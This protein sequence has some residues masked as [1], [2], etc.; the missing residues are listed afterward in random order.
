MNVVIVTNILAPY[1]IGLFEEIR[2][3]CGDLTVVTLADRHEDRSWEITD[4][5]FETRVLPGAHF[6]PSGHLVSLHWNFGMARALKELS[7]D[8]LISGGYAP[9]NLAAF[10]F[11]QRYAI[12]HISWGELI[13]EDGAENSVIKR[14]IRR[15]VISRSAGCI[16]S[17]TR[18]KR[19][20]EFYGSD[21][22]N[23][24][25]SV[26]PIDVKEYSSAAIRGK[27]RRS[28]LR[29]LPRRGGP[30]LLVV[31]RLI[32]IKGFYPLFAIYERLLKEVPELGLVIVGDGPRRAT[33][34]DHVRQRNWHQVSFVGYQAGQALSDYYAVCDLFL[35]PT[36]KDPFGAVLSE[37]MASRILSISSIHA[38]ATEDLVDDGV[39]GF[40]MDPENTEAA[41]KAILDAL[42]LTPKRREE[43]LDA[44]YERVCETDYHEAARDMA[45]FMCC[46]ANEAP[47]K[48]K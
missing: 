30:N 26:M 48:Q 25:L 20:F 9:A 13:L 28:S 14:A 17:S 31:S 45:S 43:I 23:T 3:I 24:L 33:Y 44:A 7:P 19:A 46:I 40:R 27:N 16:A 35:F 22:E 10:A 37:A 36:L 39:T 42:S 12:P 6:R 2:K 21:P 32:D 5:A 18:S 1:R 15:Y 8:I 47:R 4:F 41:C 34:E 38:A 11:C 29:S